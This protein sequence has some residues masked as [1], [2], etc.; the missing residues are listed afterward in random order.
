MSTAEAMLELAL[1]VKKDLDIIKLVG[2]QDDCVHVFT[3]EDGSCY[4]CGAKVNF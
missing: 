2:V 1:K 4:K 3:A